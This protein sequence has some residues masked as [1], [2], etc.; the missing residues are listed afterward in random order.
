MASFAAPWLPAALRDHADDIAR[1]LG[2]PDPASLPGLVDQITSTHEREIDL[3][4]LVLYAGTNVMSPLA[5]RALSTSVG[6]LPSMGPPGEKYQTGTRWIERLEVLA[7][8]LARRVFGAS[9]AEVRLQSGSLANL[10]VYTA[11]AGPGDTIVVLP[12]RA[13]GHTSHHAMGTP[14]I[15]GLRVVEMPFDAER[16]NVDV[17]G[18]REVVRRERPKLVVA[19]ASLM[20]FPHP[21]AEMADVAHDVGATLLFD[22]AHVA[23][24]VAGGRFQQPLGEGADVMT[25]STYKSFGG[26]PGGLVVTDDPAIAEAVERAAYPGM[27]ANYDASRLA[28]LSI[29]QAEVLEFWP[30]YAGRCIANARTLA[31]TLATHG[32]DVVAAGLGHTTSHHVALDARS[33]GGGI[34]TAKRLEDASI[35]TS[36]IGLPWDVP[37]SPASGVRLGTQTLTRWGLGPHEMERVADLI[38]DV[39][40]ERASTDTVAAR[41]HDL[42]QGFQT[43]GFCF[44][45]G[46][47]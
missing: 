39:L 2:T 29:A 43:V 31:T 47:S 24:L 22:A 46:A 14:G 10:A 16:M 4:S 25:C 28:S 9:F 36:A 20:L 21:L 11:L 8:M 38:A 34:A 37:G 27:T 19:G 3:G 26:P 5:R 15:R 44:P 17:E 33:L 12:E 45:H 30:D 23:G 1:A 18:L 7:S 35:L 42:R 41:V 32:L 40:M 13:G 6:S